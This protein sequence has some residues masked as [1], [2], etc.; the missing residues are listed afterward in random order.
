MNLKN[1]YKKTSL[2]LSFKIAAEHQRLGITVESEWYWVEQIPSDNSHTWP[3]SVKPER[4]FAIKMG[5]PCGSY[6]NG[7]YQG[8]EQFCR[9]YDTS[10]LGVM[11][12]RLFKQEDKGRLG[13]NVICLLA[14]G[15]KEINGD[16]EAEARGETYLWLLKEGYIK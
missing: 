5:T 16:T 6:V 11:L 12:P 10:E 4:Y 14:S 15:W 9:A 1:D 8:E 2:E 7:V 13:Y 3:G